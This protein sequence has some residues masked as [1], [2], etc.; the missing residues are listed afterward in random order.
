M[1]FI[2]WYVLS[3]FTFGLAMFFVG[4]HLCATITA[5]YLELKE[6]SNVVV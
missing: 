6:S 1:S 3:Y 4:S 5:F 2:G